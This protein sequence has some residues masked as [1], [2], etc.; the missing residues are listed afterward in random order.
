V[1]VSVG[2]GVGVSV[3]V[4]VGVSVGLGVGV[5]VD[6]GVGVSV[7]AAVWV[8]ARA[9]ATVASTSGV[10]LLLQ[11]TIKKQIT[12][13]IAIMRDIIFPPEVTEIKN[14]DLLYYT[15][16]EMP[17]HHRIDK[18]IRRCQG[19]VYLNGSGSCQHNVTFLSISWAVGAQIINC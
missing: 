18:R 8:A 2:A 5:S 14:I 16:C 9:A 4:G 19:I 1:G 3:G 7:G 6:A 10:G 13:T 12:T 15:I 11:P 17:T